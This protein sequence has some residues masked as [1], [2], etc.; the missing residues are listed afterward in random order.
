MLKRDEEIVALC[1]KKKIECDEFFDYYLF[2]P[3]TVQTTTGSYYKKFTPFYND[4]C[5]K[6]GFTRFRSRSFQIF[7]FF[8]TKLLLIFH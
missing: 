8:K 3:G 5:N 7:I 2:E 4:V 6:K 1:E